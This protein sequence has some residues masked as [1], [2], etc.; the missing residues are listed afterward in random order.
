MYQTMRP[1]FYWP[2]MAMDF[3]NTVRQYSS[4]AKERIALRR[5]SSFLRLFRG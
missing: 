4:C 3:C 2:S 5:Q 1:T